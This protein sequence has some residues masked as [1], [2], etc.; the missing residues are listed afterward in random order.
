M[1]IAMCIAAWSSMLALRHFYFTSKQTG[2]KPI[3]INE[4]EMRALK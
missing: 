4:A 1:T 3:S 2:E